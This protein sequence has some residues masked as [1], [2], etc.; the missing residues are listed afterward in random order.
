VFDVILFLGV[1]SY[2]VESQYFK[3]YN[4]CLTKFGL[5]DLPV[6]PSESIGWYPTFSKNLNIV[7]N[8][9]A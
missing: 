8:L 3:N 5:D 9:T 2:D 6:Y 1:S 4:M 7:A